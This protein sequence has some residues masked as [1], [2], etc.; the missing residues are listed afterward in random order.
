[1]KGQSGG[2]VE[3]KTASLAFLARDMDRSTM[4]FYHPFDDKKPQTKSLFE[5]KPRKTPASTEVNITSLGLFQ[6]PDMIRKIL[7][8]DGEVGPVAQ[9]HACRVY[10]VMHMRIGLP[11]Y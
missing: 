8:N 7:P 3:G 10:K 6:T 2:D 9:V 1:M 5:Q 4:S 11:D